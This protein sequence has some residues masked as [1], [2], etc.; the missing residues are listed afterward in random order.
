MDIKQEIA[1]IESLFQLIT[2][3]NQTI[4]EEGKISLL[5]KELIKDY[6]KK[7][8]S[9]YQEIAQFSGVSTESKI[10]P[11]IEMKEND[12]M[13]ISK[14]NEEQWQNLKSEF[15]ETMDAKYAPFTNLEKLNPIEQPLNIE[16]SIEPIEKKVINP[17]E[18]ISAADDLLKTIGKQK[19][20]NDQNNQSADLKIESNL[21]NKSIEFLEDEDKF[22]KILDESKEINL[23]IKKKLVIPTE[24]EEYKPTMND[25]F[26]EKIGKEKNINST[27]TKS[28]KESIMLNERI[29]FIKELFAGNSEEFAQTLAKIDGCTSVEDAFGYLESQVVGKNNWGNKEKVSIQFYNLVKKKFGII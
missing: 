17:I 19:E 28:L 16:K 21:A 24:E 22:D 26:M 2:N 25:L 9:R 27:S 20:G 7:I 1:K 5:E 15:S 11:K 23:K 12:E 6:L 18:K 29:V 3:I 14:Q 8:L 4:V 13:V 10:E